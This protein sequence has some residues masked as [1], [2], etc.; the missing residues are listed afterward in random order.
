MF[1]G[2]I[3]VTFENNFALR[4]LNFRGRWSATLK[5]RGW[6]KKIQGRTS[7]KSGGS[8]SAVGSSRDEQSVGF[9]KN[10]KIEH[11]GLLPFY[12]SCYISTTKHPILK[13]NTPF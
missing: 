11:G 3:G 2:T 9:A 5:N 7:L 6:S 4:K 12:E 1:Y 13:C 10:L 8:S